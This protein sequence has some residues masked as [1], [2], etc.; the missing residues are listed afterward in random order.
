MPPLPLVWLPKLGLQGCCQVLGVLPL[1]FSPLPSLFLPSSLSLW[2]DARSCSAPLC[3]R[4]WA[5]F[6]RWCAAQPLQHCSSHTGVGAPHLRPDRA[7][8]AV[9][10]WGAFLLSLCLPFPWGAFLSSSTLRASCGA[11]LLSKALD[12][13]PGGWG[14]PSPPPALPLASNCPVRTGPHHV[15]GWI[16]LRAQWLCLLLLARRFCP[17][18]A[19]SSLVA[20]VLGNAHSC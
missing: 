6:G 15:G 8:D 3:L 9:A 10:L 19:R 7:L 5:A 17:P 12:A 14:C 20:G 16:P 1:A 11:G 13:L 4:G 2:V 18:Q